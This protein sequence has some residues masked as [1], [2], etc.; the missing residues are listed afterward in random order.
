ME[1]GVTVEEDAI[2]Y[3]K[4]TE[5]RLGMLANVA[6]LSSLITSTIIIIIQNHHHHDHHH[7]W[8]WSLPLSSSLASFSHNC[9][10]ILHSTHPS[11]TL[12]RNTLQRIQNSETHDQKSSKEKH[13]NTLKMVL[14]FLRDCFWCKIIQPSRQ[15]AWVRS[16]FNFKQL[17]SC[18]LG[19]TIWFNRGDCPLEVDV[20]WEF[21]RCLQLN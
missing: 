9:D 2:N 16:G 14:K 5:V 20:R 17:L 3:A 18:D 7:S 8:P 19:A 12:A 15:S 6:L 13:G 21:G 1:V 4:S 11:L 10:C